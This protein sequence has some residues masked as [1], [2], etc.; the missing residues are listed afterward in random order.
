MTRDFESYESRRRM[1]LQYEALA[2]AVCEM[3]SAPAP[4]C[5]SWKQ[6]LGGL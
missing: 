4:I 1:A 2:D 6:H 5:A 3:R